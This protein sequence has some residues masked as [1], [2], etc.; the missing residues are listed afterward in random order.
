MVVDFRADGTRYRKRSPDNSRAAA[1]A[2][3]A[4]LR[5]KLSHGDSIDKVRDGDQ[6]LTFDQFAWLWFDQYV[7]PNNK[8]SEQK[9]KRYILNASLIPFFGKTPLGKITT[10]DIERYKAHALKEGI[11]RKT[12]NNRLT[13][14]RKCMTTAYDWLELPGTPPKFVWLKSSSRHGLPVAG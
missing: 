6:N 9:T 12:I 10:H 11:S 5:Q 2:Y 8:P 7:V 1:Q 4:A 13:V 14:L 3:E